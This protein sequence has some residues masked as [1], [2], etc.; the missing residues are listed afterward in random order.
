MD[1]IFSK[2]IKIAIAIGI[3]I[4]LFFILKVVINI[5]KNKKL[6]TRR[7]TVVA[8]IINISRYL[9]LFTILFSIFS[10]LEINSSTLL[11]SASFIGLIVGFGAQDLVQDMISGFFIIFE[12]HFR[13]D[14]YVS[15]N[16]IV[17]E[18]VDIGLKTTIVKT[19]EG[20]IHFFS[21]GSI[22]KLVNYSKC[23]SLAIIDIKISYENDINLV[24]KLIVNRLFNYSNIDNNIIGKPEYI[25][26]QD[27]TDTGYVLRVIA[28]T[29]PFE[30]FGVKRKI[31]RDLINTL[32]NSNVKMPNLNIKEE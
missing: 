19:W 8:L 23:N 7:K 22:D 30:H 20:E 1:E 26:I 5:I 16:D 13:V 10:I 27:S 28:T 31:R 4:A 14:D 12:D 17:G 25:G 11:A 29:A 24:E 18:V 32:V 2:V 3:G 21:N 15:I 9:I 6:D